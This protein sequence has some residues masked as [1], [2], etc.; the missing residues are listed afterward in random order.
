V[1]VNIGWVVVVVI[2]VAGVAAA[3]RLWRRARGSSDGR[4]ALLSKAALLGSWAGPQVLLLGVGPNQDLRLAAPALAPMALLA[5]CLIPQ[6][7]RSVARPLMGAATALAVLGLIL[8]TVPVRNFSWAIHQSTPAGMATLQVGTAPLGYARVPDGH[9]HS[10]GV[11]DWALDQAA[12]HNLRRPPVIGLLQTHRELNPYTLGWLSY[13]Q[14]RRAA[15]EWVDV[16]SRGLSD[17]AFES[18]FA[19]FDGIVLI[20][21]GVGGS[22]FRLIKLNE[23]MA[24][25]RLSPSV[26]VPFDDV[27]I[28]PVH[29]PGT[30]AELR[31]RNR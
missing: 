22:D 25:S 14:T 5:G 16:P 4:R 7:R 23:R 26:L 29:Q 30:R 21:D 9:D 11:L 17:G 31:W 24:I 8:H 6:V 28:V 1:N 2:G 27:R 20:P 19:R 15:V 12:R 13:A 18:Q 3:P 10:T